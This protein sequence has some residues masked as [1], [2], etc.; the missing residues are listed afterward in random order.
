MN[1]RPFIIC[2]KDLGKWLNG[3]DQSFQYSFANI[4][5]EIVGCKIRSSA[6]SLFIDVSKDGVNWM[7]INKLH[8]HNSHQTEIFEVEPTY[9]FS[10]IKLSFP[11]C[12]YSFFSNF[13]IFGKI[14]NFPQNLRKMINKEKPLLSQQSHYSFSSHENLGF[15]SFLLSLQTKEVFDNFLF[16]SYETSSNSSI[17]NLLNVDNEFWISDNMK[18]SNIIIHFFNGYMFHLT[19]FTFKTGPYSFPKSWVVT[20]YQSWSIENLK[21]FKNETELLCLFHQK[22]YEIASKNSFTIVPSLKIKFPIEFVLR[23]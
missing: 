20:G 14:T 7:K 4:N 21:E 19:G 13:Y 16:V 3:T 18:D 17:F 15:F 22:Y 1:G 6:R 10:S 8:K 12:N 9:P 2:T 5:F 11:N 23:H